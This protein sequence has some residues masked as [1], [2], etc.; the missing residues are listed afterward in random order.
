[1][2]C[3]DILYNRTTVRFINVYRPPD[4]SP[5]EYLV[6]SL[7]NEM[8]TRGPIVVTGDFNCPGI[9]W[10]RFTAPR[11]GTQD[12]ILDFFV[13]AGFSQLVK[14]PTR[15]NNILDVVCCNE[16]L[17][18][19][20]LEV[21]QPFSTSD[22]SQVTFT[23]FTDDD[24]AVAGSNTLAHQK[25]YD[26]DNANFELIAEHLA[27]VNW[28]DILSVNL[29]ADSLWTAYSEVLLEAVDKFVPSKRE[30][31]GTRHRK[32]IVWYPVSIRR[33]LA[34]KR[35]LWRCHSRNRND[36][37]ITA[38]Y[39]SAERECRQLIH[40]FELK[41][42]Q[43]VISSNNIGTFFKFV[44]KKLSSRN[45]VGA[46]RNKLDG[47][48]IVN[49]DDRANALNSY[50]GS[51]CADDNGTTPTIARTLPGNECIDSID[52]SPLKI[53]SAI[54]KMKNT[55]S[56]G[57]DGF[58]PILFK[59][60]A[61]VLAGPLSLLFTS[62][63]SVGRIPRDWTHAIVTPVYKGGDASEMSNYRPISLTCV[64]CKIME[65]VIT[66]DLLTYLRS[67]NVI[68]SRQHGFLSR[69][70]TST[71]LLESLNDW[72]IAIRDKRSVLVAYID[73]AKAFDTVCHAKLLSKLAAY[74]ITGELFNWI[75]SFLKGRTQQ[76]KI[77][78]VLSHS[79][80]LASGV[81]QGSVIGPLLF[82][83]YI[84]DVIAVLAT[85]GCVCQLY[86]D[87]LKLYT[88]LHTNASVF[89]LQRRLDELQAWS[90]AWQLKI[91]FKKC[92]SLL[93]NRLGSE[94]NSALTLGKNE[95]TRVDEVKD[96]G[97]TIDGKL[98]FTSHINRI[99]AKA[100]SRVNLIFKCFISKDIATL[101]RAFNVYV[102]P[103]LEY[104]SCVWSP[105]HITDI[106]Q[107][108]AVQRNFTKRLPGYTAL[109]YKDR[110]KRLKM[111]TL[112]LRRLRQDLVL[113]YEILAG[114]TDVN[115][116]DFFTV[117]NS[118]HCTR[119]HCYKLQANHSRVDVR[120]FFFA[121]RVVPIWNS[122]PATA[123]DFASLQTFRN[124][125]ANANLANFL[126]V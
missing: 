14:E 79:I 8:R 114:L 47:G 53:S 88:V 54:R 21:L 33:A 35:C 66:V 125:L 13:S 65:R 81:V 89:D 44:N 106:N 60:L 101:V 17:I 45:G 111:E 122:L 3:F 73:Y 19:C 48:V 87:D 85:E 98:K 26:W 116:A 46:L 51:V 11:D 30:A 20:N 69:R 92:V 58:P 68:D 39:K 6:E 105:Y 61:P 71:N 93:I 75:A 72:T 77:G 70:S 2:C 29:T 82:L 28:Y 117:A 96:L 74:G 5:A 120:K 123:E 27:T 95:L 34:R 126:V 25:Y 55:K 32:Q 64:V 40:M 102:R 43:K 115:V 7:C 22:H 12:K 67:N 16:P 113:T 42:E 56:S 86:A 118:S 103:L 90:D 104:A 18:I 124:F 78:S 112:E 108:E 107:I 1:M 24:C 59:K 109:S 94:P 80:S 49:D 121:E 62:L 91:S 37:N 15:G 23:V 36:E 84:N 38:A 31:L 63:M 41:K 4:C 9:D 10:D 83:L 119:G 76:T 99:V 50:F 52:F 97:V 110:L 100:F 57:P